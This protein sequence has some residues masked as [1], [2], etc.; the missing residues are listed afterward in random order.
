MLVGERWKNT[1][2]ATDKGSAEH[3]VDS[4]NKVRRDFRLASVELN[5]RTCPVVAH[6][7]KRPPAVLNMS[8]VVGVLLSYGD[9]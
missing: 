7:Q 8:R 2:T 1:T 3:G 5:N 9:E 6:R 4:I